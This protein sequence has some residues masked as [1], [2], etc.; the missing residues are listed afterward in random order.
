MVGAEVVEVEELDIVMRGIEMKDERRT[1]EGC[2][3]AERA[4][5]GSEQVRVVLKERLKQ[6]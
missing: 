4:R 5:K 2:D 3:R 1:K 6:E